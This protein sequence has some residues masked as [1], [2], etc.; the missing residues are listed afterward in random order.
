MVFA[1][2]N[3]FIIPALNLDKIGNDTESYIFLESA[4]A[5]K[6]KKDNSLVI[7]RDLYEGNVSFKDSEIGFNKKRMRIMILLGRQN[8]IAR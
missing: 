3:T 8:I 1:I 7:L 5:I 4:K 2:I 6:R